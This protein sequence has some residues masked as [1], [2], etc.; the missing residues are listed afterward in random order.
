[1][2]SNIEA[3]VDKVLDALLGADDSTAGKLATKVREQIEPQ[4]AE[5]VNGMQEQIDALKEHA[6]KGPP[7]G[8]PSRSVMAPPW[9]HGTKLA[10][11]LGMPDPNW[12]NPDA[13]GASL[14]GR[15]ASFGE[16][17]RS[18]IRRDMK[19]VADE[20]LVDVSSRGDLRIAAELT[21]EE[22]ELGGALVPEEFRPMLLTM[23]LQMNS[24]RS[25]AMV[26]PMGSSQLSIPAIRDETHADGTTF[27]GVRFNWL[28]VNDTIGATEP[29]FKLVQLVARALAGRTLIPNTLLEDSIVTVPA[30][31]MNL[32]Q[33]AVPWTEEREFIRGDGVGKPLGILNS[34]AV[35]TQARENTGKFSVADVFELESHLPP[36][37]MGRAVWMMHPNVLPQLGT[38]NDGDVQ[39]WHPALSADM[40]STLNGRPIIFNEHM[41]GLGSRGDVV[42]VD[43]MYY[44]IGDRQALSMMASPHERFSSNQTVLRAVERI[45]GTPWLDTPITL[46]QGSHQ[47]SP[48]VVLV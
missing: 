14:D 29:T 39:S 42:L 11:A 10:Q 45:D 21:G 13:P 7:P 9:A 33:Q 8:E 16:F 28:E 32:Y 40:P 4:V 3:Q 27:G 24:I 30:L 22:V 23:Q 15:F 34:P 12:H 43:W 41:S 31:I 36:G 26:L 25:R 44:L 38:L 37:S 2:E 6:A 46:A 17:V 20:R 18:V 5:R 19:G 35:V 1:M 47:V 48:F